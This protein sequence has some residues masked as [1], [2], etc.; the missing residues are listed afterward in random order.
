MKR[1]KKECKTESKAHPTGLINDLAPEFGSQCLIATQIT[2]T[3]GY[4]LKDG[5]KTRIEMK[6]KS[7]NTKSILSSACSGY[8]RIQSAAFVACN[9]SI[10]L[11]HGNTRNEK[12]STVP[13]YRYLL[14]PN[15]YPIFYKTFFD[16]LHMY[17]YDIRP[18]SRLLNMYIHK[19]HPF[20]HT[21]AHTHLRM[22]L[23]LHILHTQILKIG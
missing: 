5:I 18:C 11:A 15:F 7:V 6:K 8:V 16:T 4:V 12:P 2:P 1:K 19:E 9:K 10:Y 21:H 13:A 20:N 23:L 3:K 17:K 22:H 14:K